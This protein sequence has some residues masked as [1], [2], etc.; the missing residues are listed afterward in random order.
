MRQDASQV[1]YTRLLFVCFPGVTTHCGCIFTAFLASSFSR[2]LD[3]TQRHATVGKTPLD[4]WSRVI[5]PSQR[6]LTD[7]TQHS[8]QTSIHASG[9]IRTHNLSRRTAEDLRLRPRG[10]WDRLNYTR[11]LPQ[12]ITKPDGLL[13]TE[14]LTTIWFSFTNKGTNQAPI[15]IVAFCQYT[16]SERISVCLS[17]V[18]ISREY[19]M[20]CDPTSPTCR[21]ATQ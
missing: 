15:S 21:P 18:E 17:A 9:G 11:L 16:Y 4:D 8:Q 14:V 5:N 7:N 6:P 19:P 2:F 12:N 13:Q 3:H 1:N 20:Q 10:H